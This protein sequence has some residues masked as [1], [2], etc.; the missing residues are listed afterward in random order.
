MTKALADLHREAGKIQKDQ[1]QQSTGNYLLA[2]EAFANEVEADPTNEEKLT[3]LVQSYLDLAQASEDSAP[4][5][6]L[7]HHV[8]TN[9]IKTDSSHLKRLRDFSRREA[10]LA[11]G[12]HPPLL[13]PGAI[14]NYYDDR[15][16]PPADWHLPTFDA[17]SWKQGPAPLGYGDG[18]EAT[19]L[20][21]GSDPDNKRITS[22]FRHQF[23][24]SEVPDTILLN[25][26][27][28]DGA[29]VFI[30]G[31]EVVRSG[32]PDGPLTPETFA[33]N[34]AMGFDERVFHS[35]L[36]EEHH[37]VSGENTIAV[38]LHQNEP[39]SSDLSLDLEIYDPSTLPDLEEHLT[40]EKLK[41]LPIPKPISATLK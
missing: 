26:Q 30:N 2:A 41:E 38:E 19:E 17:S 36:I 15:K 31:K 9:F 7:A 10:I 3:L 33:N 20:N 32:L 1:G 40:R 27:R 29:L 6:A 22:W 13:S 4:I 5:F 23:Q 37:L 18:N 39:Q 28:D 25:L 34:I 21:Y 24:L 8:L 12:N 14:W 16:A 11:L 35:Y